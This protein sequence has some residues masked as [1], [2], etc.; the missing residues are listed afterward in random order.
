M[1]MVDSLEFLYLPEQLAGKVD[2]L[3]EHLPRLLVLVLLAHVHPVHRV[4]SLVQTQD[5]LG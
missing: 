4:H 5:R 3:V 2:G 1:T